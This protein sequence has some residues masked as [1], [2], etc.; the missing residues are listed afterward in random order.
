MKKEWVRSGEWRLADNQPL[1]NV[2]VKKH[3]RATGEETGRGGEELQKTIIWIF[4][5]FF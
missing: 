5:L 4:F 3:G 1:K 2:R